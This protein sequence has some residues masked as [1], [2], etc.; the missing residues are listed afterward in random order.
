MSISDIEAYL[1]IVLFCLVYVF[2]FIKKYN[3]LIASRDKYDPD[4]VT[5]GFTSKPK[6][7]FDAIK[8][9]IFKIPV[10]NV[11]ILY[12]DRIYY[13]D[14]NHLFTGRRVLPQDISRDVILRH[15]NFSKDVDFSTVL[16][17]SFEVD[18]SKLTLNL[19]EQLASNLL[20][21]L[22]LVENSH[23]AAKLLDL[24]G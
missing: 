22:G 23:S 15:L 17:Q 6:T 4:V 12:K 21:G 7:F 5:L 10:S 24:L 11:S 16:E 3:F 8:M 20:I 18:H 2:L 19:N 9:L 13:Y 1:L 14:D